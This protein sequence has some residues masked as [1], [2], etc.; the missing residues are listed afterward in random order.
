MTYANDHDINQMLIFK[1]WCFKGLWDCYR[2]V[3]VVMVQTAQLY[4]SNRVKI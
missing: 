1:T 4:T 2:P 3:E